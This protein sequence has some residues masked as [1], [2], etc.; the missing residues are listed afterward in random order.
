[1]TELVLG[2]EQVMFLN[3]FRSVGK[4]HGSF[5]LRPIPLFRDLARTRSKAKGFMA[6]NCQ[7]NNIMIFHSS[8]KH[9]VIIISIK[10][11]E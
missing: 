11:I 8:T 5:P 7:F 4:F 6:R 10:L 2:P 1:M 3:I 9:N